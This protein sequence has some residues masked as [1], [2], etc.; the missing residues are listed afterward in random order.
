MSIFNRQHLSFQSF[1]IELDAMALAY[2]DNDVHVTRN[3][4]P[5]PEELIKQIL[6]AEMKR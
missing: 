2:R 3:E 1:A 5:A 6:N 4:G